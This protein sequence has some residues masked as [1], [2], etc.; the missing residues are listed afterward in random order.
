MK[1]FGTE[2]QSTARADSLDTWHSA[3]DTT[4]ATKCIRCFASR[5]PANKGRGRRRVAT[6][7]EATLPATVDATVHATM[8]AAPQRAF[9][10]R[11]AGGACAAA[12][13]NDQVQSFGSGVWHAKTQWPRWA[14]TVSYERPSFVD[15]VVTRLMKQM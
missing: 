4:G 11:C 6:C 2:T 1:R 9:V 13:A 8:V 15:V 7:F 10:R 3:E 12:Q 14:F 5:R